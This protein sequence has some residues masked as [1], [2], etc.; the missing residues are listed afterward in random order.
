[1]LTKR[2]LQLLRP[3]IRAEGSE[4]LATADARSIWLTQF[5]GGSSHV[6]ERIIR[7]R[8]CARFRVGTFFLSGFKETVGQ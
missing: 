1:M 2:S 6:I 3:T 8:P 4:V 7:M 5:S